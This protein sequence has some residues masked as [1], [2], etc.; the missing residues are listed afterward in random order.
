[1]ASFATSSRQS[2]GRG[3]HDRCSFTLVEMMVA[4]GVFS[5]LMTMLLQ[6]LIMAMRTWQ[7]VEERTDAFREARGAL[8]MLSRDLGNLASAS[9]T[10]NLALC[11]FYRLPSLQSYVPDPAAERNGHE[12]YALSLLPNDAKG[13]LC[14]VGYYCVWDNRYGM[15]MLKRHFKNSQQTL[16]S[17][18]QVP[19]RLASSSDDALFEPTGSDS[20][21]VD[22]LAPG[23]WDFKVKAYDRSGQPVTALVFTT[24]LPAFVQVEFKALNMSAAPK[25]K[26]LNIKS[27]DWS[28]TE[29]AVYKTHIAPAMQTFSTRISLALGRGGE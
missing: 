8:Y 15:F 19:F 20:A 3:P 14:A 23:I 1:M 26:A 12:I 2:L 25:L 9:G 27:E 16:Q 5:L 18:T 10:T 7:V 21:T 13:D 4:M 22:T 11:D 6:L 28:N 17:L 29:S 24:N